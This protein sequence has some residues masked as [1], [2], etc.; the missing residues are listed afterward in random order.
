[1]NGFLAALPFFSDKR[2]SMEVSADPVYLDDSEGMS[3][4]AK[5]VN[6]MPVVSGVD[7][8]LGR[9]EVRVPVYKGPSGVEKY[10]QAKQGFY[11]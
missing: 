3:G 9:Q 11:Q 1:M 10:L 7:K 8:Y 5:Y 4:V 2:S 6:N